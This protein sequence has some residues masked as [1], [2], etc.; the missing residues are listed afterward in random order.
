MIRKGKRRQSANERRRTREGRK[1]G[2]GIAENRIEAGKTDER[3]GIDG[4]GGGN[5]SREW[6]VA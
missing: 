4:Y 3:K 1:K 6:E 2:E 5:E